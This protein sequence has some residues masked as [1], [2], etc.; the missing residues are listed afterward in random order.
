MIQKVLA[1]FFARER[2]VAQTIQTRPATSIKLTP[3]MEK[4]YPSAC[5]VRWTTSGQKPTWME[6]HL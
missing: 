2:R 1:L 6:S 4:P 3:A 5:A